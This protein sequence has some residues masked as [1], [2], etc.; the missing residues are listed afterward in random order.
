MWR[1]RYAVTAVFGLIACVSSCSLILN[2]DPDGLPCGANKECADTY[3]CM[4][5]ECVADG[6]IPE[7]STCSQ[8]PQC[9]GAPD[10]TC[11]SNPFTCRRRCTKPFETNSVCRSDE[12]EYCRPEINRGT[13]GQAIGTCVKSECL[14]DNDCE[15]DRSC[16]SITSTALACMQL[17]QYDFDDLLNE[18]LDRCGGSTSGQQYCQPVG[19]RDNRTFV[20]LDLPD[21]ASRQAVGDPCDPLVSP[22]VVGA[23]CVID[24]KCYKLCDETAL[25]PVPQ[26]GATEVCCPISSGG[27]ARVCKAESC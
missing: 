14:T 7:D 16:V 18:Y 20:C 2:W 13:V 8:E 25:P 5:S 12:R 6:S 11:G 19:P 17:C 22:C 3:S 23:A 10:V 1:G 15:V 4:V 27:T 26:C 21:D 9:E 24:K